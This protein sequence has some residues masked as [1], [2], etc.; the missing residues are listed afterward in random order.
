MTAIS[1]T[2]S[3]IIS[4]FITI[5]F[6]QTSQLGHDKEKKVKEFIIENGKKQNNA[7]PRQSSDRPSDASLMRRRN[8]PQDSI[9]DHSQ[10]SSPDHNQDEPS[11]RF[12]NNQTGR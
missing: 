3:S 8:L 10:D 12:S 4:S 9:S 5:Y 11:N 7:I 2:G 6:K 1:L